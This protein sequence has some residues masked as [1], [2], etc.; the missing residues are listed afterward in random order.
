MWLAFVTS[1]L[2]QLSEQKK[3]TEATGID[4]YSYAKQPKEEK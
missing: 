4:L 3:L 2:V 1:K